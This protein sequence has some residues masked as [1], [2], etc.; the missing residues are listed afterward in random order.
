MLTRFLDDV[1]EGDVISPRRMA[2]RLRVPITDLSRLVNVN[3]NALASQ[4]DSPK[5]QRN[6]GEVAR[7]ITHAALLS[8]DE[9]KAIIWFR[10]QPLPG[11]AGKT[12]FELVESG[13]ADAVIAY[14]QS[15]E[16]GVYA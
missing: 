10:H 12:A 2:E 7:I 15:L 13:H 9:G 16:A 11:F 5:V 8:Q 3:R 14:L 1:T 6:L 4:C